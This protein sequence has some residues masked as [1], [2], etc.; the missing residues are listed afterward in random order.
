MKKELIEIVGEAIKESLPDAAVK[1]ALDEIGP[2][3]GKTIIVSVGKAGWQMAKA[4]ADCLKGSYDAGY[5]ITKYEHSKGDIPKFTIFEAGHPVLDENSVSSTEAVIKAV[6]NL[7]AE[8]RV[9]FLLSGGGSALFESPAIS[10]AEFTQINKDLLACGADIVEMNTIRK[11]ISNVKGG[12][13]AKICAPAHVYSII[14]SDIVG[15]HPDMIA[16]GPAYPDSSS[17][18]DALNIVK[19]YGLKFS[20]K[21]MEMLKAE[22]VKELDNITTLVTGGVAQLCASAA[23]ACKRHGYET[24]ML[25]DNLSCEARDAGSFLGTIGSYYAGCGKKMAFVAGGETVVHLKGHGRGGRNQEIALAAAEKIAGLEGVAVISVGSDGTD[26]PT[27]AAG[28][29]VD[30]KTAGTLL[31]KGLKIFDILEDNDAYNGLKEADGLVITG[32]TG[33]NVNDVAIVTVE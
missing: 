2:C 17:S 15:D 14:L 20:D 12:R 26:G 16:S 11:R 33:T 22:P 19:K 32:A 25:G 31:S 4:A 6:E 28:G 13:F 7:K 5:V 3:T 1:R 9:L 30:G 24:I 10:L 8:D 18:E 29:V 23:E 21:V 27:D